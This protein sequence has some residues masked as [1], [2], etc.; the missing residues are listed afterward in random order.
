VYRLICW[1]EWESKSLSLFEW[2]LEFQAVEA[3][4]DVLA[5]SED[6]KKEATFLARAEQVRTPAKRHQ[7]TDEIMES[8]FVVLGWRG[9]PYQKILPDEGSVE[10]ENQISIGLKK[11]V[12]TRV[13]AGVESKLESMGKGMVELLN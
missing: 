4:D 7:E 10:L 9:D 8:D 2:N 3:I 12:V 5:T 1:C 11:G 13:V 6:V